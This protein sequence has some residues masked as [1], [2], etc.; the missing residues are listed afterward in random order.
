[1]NMHSI[2]I[3]SLRMTMLLWARYCTPVIGFPDAWLLPSL[4]ALQGNHTAR[5]Q[6]L[7][8][9]V[10]QL[11]SG[12]TKVEPASGRGYWFHVSAPNYF[13]LVNVLKK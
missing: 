11:D 7:L 12:Q 3:V 1:M 6:K 5:K 8:S 2:L 4:F 10:L 9:A 13:V